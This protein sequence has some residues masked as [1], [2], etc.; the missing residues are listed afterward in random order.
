MTD[1]CATLNI[2]G[3]HKTLPAKLKENLLT[4]VQKTL[5]FIF[6]WYEYWIFSHFIG[7]ES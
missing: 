1:L 7:N 2:L 6:D 4:S 3:W 5:K